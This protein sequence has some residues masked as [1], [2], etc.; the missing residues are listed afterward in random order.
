MSIKARGSRTSVL[1]LFS[2][3]IILFRLLPSLVSTEVCSGE[4]ACVAPSD[5]QKNAVLGKH[6]KKK[7]VGTSKLSSNV[8]NRTFWRLGG[9]TRTNLDKDFLGTRD[10][11]PLEIRVNNER[12]F[13]VEPHGTGTPSL[14][15]GFSD[16]SADGVG[17]TV[18]GGGGRGR[19]FDSPNRANGRFSTIGGGLG[20]VAGDISNNRAN[21]VSGGQDNK[22][23]GFFDTVGGGE[24]N[25]AGVKGLIDEGGS[26]VAGGRGNVATGLASTVGG[27]S[28]NIASGNLAT[29][30]GGGGFPNIAS[31][32]ASTI[33]GGSRNETS[34]TG[35]TVGGG[36]FNEASG[37][38]ATVSGGGTNM[39][40][41]DFSVVPGGNENHAAGENSFAA[42]HMATAAH[43]GSFVWADSSPSDRA[44][45]RRFSSTNDNQ[46][47]VRS[48]G[49]TRIFSDNAASVGVELMPGANA[50]SVLSDRNR[51]ENVT[52]VKA[53]EILYRLSRIP[54]T[55]WNLK[56]QDPSI[57]HLGPMAQDFYAAFGLGES[58]RS[59]STSDADGVAFISIQALHLITKEQEAHM[60]TLRQQYIELEERVA[61]LAKRVGAN[62]ASMPLFSSDL[63]PSG[64]F[65]GGLLLVGYSRLNRR[66]KA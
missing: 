3:L 36:T 6:I 59:I 60:V 40:E 22:A 31:G 62:R 58:D 19:G 45:P 46:F 13:R 10:D 43:D 12:A 30:S 47:S 27:G 39:A 28:N 4:E 16:N 63:L 21:T 20:N 44:G 1:Y 26:T 23:L 53:K 7:A 42:G 14:V 25:T 57:H 11:E 61:T 8:L 34:G 37:L 29:I 65:L 50:W 15:G 41:G 48:A 55:Q 24:N 66:S 51:K 17:A 35:S 5:I 33:G 49:G 38:A 2:I 54:I 64:L 9:N 56:S 32:S 18:S 52:P